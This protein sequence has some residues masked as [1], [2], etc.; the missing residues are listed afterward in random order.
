M[1]TVPSFCLSSC[2]KHR[3]ILTHALALAAPGL[4][5]AAEAGTNAA[6]HLLFQTDEAGSP[7]LRAEAG[8][9]PHHDRGA[10]HQHHI[11][12]R[13]VIQLGDETVETHRAGV[14]GHLDD[15]R[16][17]AVLF[18]AV[19]LIA[20][21]E[22]D[23]RLDAASR[24]LPGELVHGGGADAAA[25]DGDFLILAQDV[26]HI[27][28]VAHGA[29]ELEAVTLFQGSQ[30]AGSLAHD[31]VQE[32]DGLG[33]GI[34]LVDADGPG[35]EGSFICAPGTQGEELPRVGD[36]LAVRPEGGQ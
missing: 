15:A 20:E 28:A 35:Q 27:K 4:A 22:E 34:P 29:G 3:A 9:I 32:L 30:L 7:L 23:V 2:I 19:G 1:A 13:R 12:I 33:L 5:G 36:M 17:G 16:D 18:H 25:H 14:G 11:V 26:G 24:Q 10:A 31:G 8:G 21:A 6:G